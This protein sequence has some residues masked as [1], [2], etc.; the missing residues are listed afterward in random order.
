MMATLPTAYFFVLT[1]S[2]ALGYCAGTSVP[3]STEVP[4][5]PKAES[6]AADSDSESEEEEGVDVSGLTTVEDCKLVLA[7]R[8]DLGMS[9]GK[10]A[11][12]CSHA[13]L[14]CYKTLLSKNPALLA[15]WA[16]TGYLK[17]VVRCTD[18][19]HL[20]L[21]QAQAQSLNLC[22]RSIQDAG[23]TQ[24]AAGSTTVL[25]IAGPTALVE[26]LTGELASL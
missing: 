6:D 5:Q 16:R 12:Q 3:K 15:R 11:A 4:S 17:S 8:T 13:T 18:E 23:R 7:V 2:L 21:L 10:I 14:A 19:D 25:G 20:L 1:A 24:I 9:S 26:G 22:A